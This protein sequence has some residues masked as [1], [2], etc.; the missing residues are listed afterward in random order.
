MLG[1]APRK[2]LFLSSFTANSIARSIALLNR[3]RKAT[4]CIMFT[5]AAVVHGPVLWPCASLLAF[6]L[7]ALLHSPLAVEYGRMEGERQQRKHALI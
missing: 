3:L 5:L 1:D 4:T 2:N 6:R 7:S